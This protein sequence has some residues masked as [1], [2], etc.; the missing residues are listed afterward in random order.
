M[1]YI[2]ETKDSISLTF[3]GLLAVGF[4]IAGTFNVLNYV[5]IQILTF[6]CFGSLLAVAIYF[7]IKNERK[8]NRP[9]DKLQDD[10]H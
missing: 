6:I 4:F 3:V 1:K 9:E 2:P 10:S 5:I 8:K 7:A